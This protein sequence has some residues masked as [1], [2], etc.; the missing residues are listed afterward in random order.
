MDIE[1]MGIEFVKMIIPEIILAVL[2][3][4]LKFLKNRNLWFAKFRDWKNRKL[5]EDIVVGRIRNESDAKFWTNTKYYWFQ[6]IFI[7]IIFSILLLFC[8][9]GAFVVRLKMQNVIQSTI[10]RSDWIIIWTILLGNIVLS[11]VVA[12]Q[13]KF[14]WYIGAVIITVYVFLQM[15]YFTMDLNSFL[16][17][18]SIA[19]FMVTVALQSFLENNIFMECY[20][21]GYI[22]ISKFIRCIGIMFIIVICLEK[23]EWLT[24][25]M[26]LWMFMTT[27]E[28]MIMILGDQRDLVEVTICFKDHSAKTGEAIATCH[29]GRLLYISEEGVHKF[30]DIQNVRYIH[31]EFIN[32]GK[33]IFLWNKVYCVLKDGQVRDYDWYSCRRGDWMVFGK[34]EDNK[35]MIDI[36]PISRIKEFTRSPLQRRYITLLNN[37]QLIETGQSRS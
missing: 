15:V 27:M 7:Y 20:K 4:P 8:W 33:K 9:L 19:V 17:V 37:R 10:S 30:E 22:K 14:K 3:L 31:Y 28:Y 18:V 25:C 35:R 11:A 5:I 1:A 12:S 26:Y 2:P 21:N 23:R 32:S 16:R 13:K 29:D 36:F 34:A 6:L 24:Y